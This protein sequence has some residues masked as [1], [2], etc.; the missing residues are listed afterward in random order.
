MAKRRKVVKYHKRLISLNVG[1]ITFG[2]IFLYLIINIF[3]YMSKDTVST[4]E[5]KQ[6]VMQ[7]S[8]STTG[9]VLRDEKIVN[10]TTAGYINYYVRDGERTAKRATVYSIGESD[11]IFDYLSQ[12]A[13]EKGTIN[14]ADFVEIREQISVF[15]NYYDNNTFSDVYD[16]KYN[17]NNTILELTNDNSLKKLEQSLSD[18]G[19]TDSFKKVAS[20]QSGIVAYSM[21]GYEK[22]T[23]DKITKDSFDTSKYKKVQLKSGELVKANSPVYKITNGENWSVVIPLTKEQQNALTDNSTVNVTFTKD[24]LTIPASVTTF[25]NDGQA[26]ASLSFQ[27]YMIRYINDRFLDIEVILQ[28]VSGLKIPTTSIVEKDFYQIPVSYLSKGSNSST[29]NSLNVQT[30]DKKGDIAVK[31]VTPTIVLQNKKY[32]YIDIDKTDTDSPIKE[33]SVISANNSKSTFQISATKKLKGVYCVNKGYATFKIIDI[34][35]TSDNY[36]IIEDSLSN[37]ITPYDHIILNSKTVDEN[38][39]IY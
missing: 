4:Y 11:K 21:D 27:S 2:V 12:A 24:N 26:Y 19:I 33:D 22:L 8:I 13:E 3:I 29:A 28:S 25:E 9:I 18:S 31:Q 39:K 1:T 10:S 5:V 23:T 7:K 38:E 6:D 15:N 37:S 14:S 16:F 17:L 32:C 30:I 20:K 34:K 36:T 35:H